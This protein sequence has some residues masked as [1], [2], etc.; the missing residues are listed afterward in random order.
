MANTILPN[1]FLKVSINSISEGATWP[2][3]SNPSD[4]WNTAVYQWYLTCE[5]YPQTHSSPFTD[6]PYEYNGED[7]RVG[8]W[9]ASGDPVKA[10]KIIA[11]TAQTPNSITL[12]VEDVERFNIFSDPTGNGSGIFGTGD[13][14]IFDL[15]DDALPIIYPID[16]SMV[17]SPNFS[18]DLI[19]RFRINN[20]VYRYRIDQA[21]HGLIVGDEIYLDKDDGL[22]KKLIPGE[23]PLGRV[24]DTYD[25]PDTFLFSPVNRIEEGIIPPLPGVPGDIIYYDDLNPGELTLTPSLRA[26]YLKINNTTGMQIEEGVTPDAV[27]IYPNIAS[28]PVTSKVGHMAY[29]TDRGNGEWGLYMYTITGWVEMANQDSA[30]TDAKTLVVDF[31]HNSFSPMHIGTLSAG[32]RVTLIT[33]E[34]LDTFNGTIFSF[35]IGDTVDNFKLLSM[36]D[37]DFGKAGI[38]SI[39]SSV[40]FN[41]GSDTD[42]YLFF[43]IGGNTQGLA[44][45]A[46][47]Y[48]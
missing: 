25:S 5:I 31:Y 21:S 22:C 48:V 32:S 36:D 41:G 6:T 29:V 27:S 39:Q 16:P 34:V 10:V 15:G 44:K 19:S 28:R 45:I 37:V 17:I 13:G 46:V 20:P 47:S 18:N 2:Y 38:Y 35:G 43:N 3:S 11:I 8:M 4:P 1:K 12:T 30:A 24:V 14:Y 40:V 9:I 7:I 26:A 33:V 42:I 23:Q